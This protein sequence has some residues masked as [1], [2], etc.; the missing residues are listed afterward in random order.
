MDKVKRLKVLVLA[1]PIAIIV[2]GSICLIYRYEIG[3]DSTD[4]EVTVNSIK[5]NTIKL[6]ENDATVDYFLEELNKIEYTQTD[7]EL[8]QNI[9]RDDIINELKLI[10]SIESEEHQGITRYQLAHTLYRLIVSENKLPSIRGYQVNYTDNEELPEIYTTAIA[11]TTYL[12]LYEFGEKFDGYKYTTQQEVAEAMGKCKK[13]LAEYKTAED[14]T[15]EVSAEKSTERVILENEAAE[16]LR[17]AVVQD[18][19]NGQSIAKFKKPMTLGEIESNIESLAELNLNNCTNM[20]NGEYTEKIYNEY[21]NIGEGLLDHK[22]LDS[23]EINILGMTRVAA[24]KFEVKINE[25]N[26]IILSNDLVD[27]SL[28]TA[29]AGVVSIVGIRE[30]KVVSIGEYYIDMP[31]REIQ[32]PNTAIDSIAFVVPKGTLDNS[33]VYGVNADN[34]VL[35]VM[36]LTPEDTVSIRELGVRD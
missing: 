27:A 3:K 21:I 23:V 1:I 14:T 11:Y 2:I 34:F 35:A 24:V 13:Y 22:M 26:K 16:I 9:L 31:Y 17:E 25:Y 29:L 5:D 28:D 36:K 10:K 8:T 15:T 32:M 7:L 30:S 19:L 33:L 12:G 6:G 4:T 18:S 20:N